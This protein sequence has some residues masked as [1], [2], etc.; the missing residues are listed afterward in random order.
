MYSL[1]GDKKF[2][3][4]WLLILLNMHW[5]LDAPACTKQKLHSLS[6]HPAGQPPSNLVSCGVSGF[7]GSSL[8]GCFF[9]VIFFLLSA[10][11]WKQHFGNVH[12]YKLG[13]LI[14]Q[15]AIIKNPVFNV[16]PVEIKPCFLQKRH[17][18]SG[19]SLARLQAIGTMLFAHFSF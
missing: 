12:I 2:C 1:F 13:Y 11:L 8:F 14:Y 6:N 10:S 15:V 17:N 18:L 3:T 5:F 7:I 4:I 16:Y 19:K 9:Y